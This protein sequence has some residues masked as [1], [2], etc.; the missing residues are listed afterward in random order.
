MKTKAKKFSH[1]LLALF[2]AVIMA[3]TCF[4]G[5]LS[6]FAASKDIKYVDDAVVYNELA[7]PVLSDE[8]VATAILDFADEMIAEYLAPI[9]PQLG[10]LL[11]GVSIPVVTLNH[12]TSKRQIEVKALGTTWVSVTVKLDS[13]DGLLETLESAHEALHG[14]L[15]NLIQRFGL[16]LG[17]IPELDLNAA[18]GLRRTKSSSCDILRGVLGL[19]YENNDVIFGNLLRG[20][21]TLGVIPLDVYDTLGGLFGAPDGYESNFVYNIVQNLLFNNTQWFT[22]EEKTAYLDGSKD[23][24]FDT[25]LLEKMTAEL[26]NKINVLVTYPDGTNSG[27]RKAAIEAKM[28]AEGKTYEQ[29]AAAL[30]YDPNLKYSTE[31]G[32]ENNILLF[33]YGNEKIELKPEDSLFSFGYQALAMAWKTVLKDTVKLLHVNYDVDR[34]H[35]SNFDNQYMYWYT[36]TV[37]A[38][39]SSNPEAMYAAANVERWAAD[40][41]EA[42]DATSADEFL[43]WVKHNFEYDRGIVDD[44][45]GTWRDINPNTLI[46]KIRYSPLADYYFD[47]QTGPIN[48]YFMQLGTANL[49]NFFDNE[50]KEYSSL[51]AGLNDALVAAVK[52]IFVQSDNVYVNE[53]GD[54]TVPTM[55][56]T[57]KTFSTIGDTEIRAI[58]NALTENALDVI[59]YVADT[60]DQNILAAFYEENG[61]GAELTEQNLEEAMIPLLIAALGKINLGSGALK[62]IIHP[63]DWDAAKDAEA[64]VFIALREYLSYVLPQNDYNVYISRD[65]DNNIEATL[66]GTI[67]P[68]A[69]DAIIYIIESAVQVTDDSGKVWKAEDPNHNNKADIFALL[70]NVIC[71][72]ANYYSVPTGKAY[73][74]APLIGLCDKNGNSE[75]KNGDNTT[76]WDNINTLF[77]KFFPVLGEI[78]GKGRGQ[79]DSEEL[80]WE[81]IVMGMLEI[82]AKHDSGFGGVSNFIYRFLSIVSSAP[83][84]SQRIT[85]VVYDVLKDFFNGLFG[86][87]YDGQKWTPIPDRSSTTPFD[88][89]LQK[90]ALAGT[91]SDNVGAVQK[92]INNFVEFSGFGWDGVNTYPDTILPGLLFALNTA[93]NYLKILPGIADHKLELATAEFADPVVEGA[94]ANSSANSTLSF[95]NNCAGVNVAY[96]DGMKDSVTQLSRYYMQIT[97]VKVTG[98]ASVSLG[99]YS[100]DII[101]PGGTVN[102]TTSA[103]YSPDAGTDKCIYTAEIT[104]NILDANKTVLHENLVARAYQYISG[105]ATWASEVYPATVDGKTRVDDSGLYQL[106][107]ELETND[108]N[109]TKT[110]SKGGFKSFTTAQFG[111]SSGGIGGSSQWA[112]VALYPE[113]VVVDNDTLDLVGNYGIR[114]RNVRTKGTLS[115]TKRIDGI[116]YYDDNVSVYDDASGSYKTMTNANAIPVFDKTTGDLLK[117]ERYD[118]STDGGQTWQRNYGSMDN[119]GDTING[120]LGY[121]Y[122]E[123]YGDG[124]DNNKGIVGTIADDKQ[125]DFRVRTHVAYTLQEARD[126]GIIAAFHKNDKTGLYD[127]I[128]LA[129][130]NGTNYDTTLALISMRGPVDGFYLNTGKISVGT[131]NSQYLSFIKY[132]GTTE[133]QPTTEAIDVNVRFYTSQDSAGAGKATYK[134]LY[135]DKSSSAASVTERYDE[136]SSILSNYKD[137]DFSSPE[138][139]ATAQ[140]A[141]TKALAAI[142]TAI[143]PASAVKLN[144]KTSRQ[145]V[146]ASSTSTTGDAAL[147]PARSADTVKI[148]TSILNI[149]DYDSANDLYFYDKEHVAGIYL[150]DEPLTSADV[151]TVNGVLQD[152]CGAPVTLVDG[153]YYYTNSIAYTTEWDTKTFQDAPYLKETGVQATDGSGNKLYNQIQFTHYNM[154]GQNVRYVDQWAV[155]VPQT[156]YQLVPIADGVDTRG[157]YTQTNDYIQWAIEY[158][159]KNIRSDFADQLLEQVSDIRYGLNA[160]NFEVVT[161]NKMVDMGQTIESQYS[162]DI[163]YT[164]DEVVIGA[165]GKATTEAVTYTD[166]ISYKDLNGYLNDPNNREISYVAKSSLSSVQVDEYLRLFNIFMDKVVERGYNGKQLEAEI[167]CAS[168]NPYTA[169][170]VT[171]ATEDSAAVVKKVGDVEPRFGAWSEDG[172]LVNE[173]DP[174]YTEETW[175]AYVNALADAIALAQHGNTDYA[176]ADKAYYD[177]EDKD[178]YDAQVTDVYRVDTALQRA[179]IALEEAPSDDTITI[180][181]TI[182]IAT[183]TT[184]TASTVGIVGIGVYVDGELVATSEKDGTFT[185]VVPKGTT[186]LTIKGDTT[187]DRIVTLTG[188]ADVTGAIIPIVICDYNRDKLINTIDYSV[189]GTALSGAYNVYCDFN[190]DSNV[191]TLDYGVFGA[192]YGKTVVYDALAL[193]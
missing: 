152:V 107:E 27:T 23:F 47:M 76:I 190:G 95:T 113:Y 40:V 96:V 172:T 144:D 134:Y 42:Y 177:T 117:H 135:V 119:G 142:A 15:L 45:T 36:D 74:V 75:I 12:N 185:A 109:Q 159:S 93:N 104:Y 167:E 85:D 6:A 143:T 61:A 184:G 22:D 66:E 191:N 5:A 161:Y 19:I 120:Y 84:Q 2:M 179:E 126:A 71:Q 128:Y 94:T 39:D 90:T 55:R 98:N 103:P 171:T 49:D 69:R 30:G 186:E 133:I 50:Y 58:T 67:L 56:T 164:K 127:H 52:D 170:T 116:Y 8:Q 137:G 140:Q 189:F 145:F 24:K 150:A 178:N 21:F 53:P 34:G 92:V 17:I 125:K 192:F 188:E 99:S 32:Q 81:D 154:N 108:A 165:D 33:A 115:Q 68:M 4:S 77:D 151:R 141:L 156:S 106:N 100:K 31:R 180:S 175:T 65:E 70:N 89:L 51:I 54:I 20:T 26:L 129:T 149:A 132:D 130:G 44:A 173:G 105:A 157:I 7:W 35:G 9:E 57:G 131:N 59:Q 111:S 18:E 176:H 80:I 158:V 182:K 46:N 174:V 163:T 91:G 29:A 48:L 73:G 148:P 72:F 155:M 160:N 60:M 123:I 183:N 181:G 37:G 28:E 122:T 101:A 136:L 25:V 78:Q 38:W 82:S 13:V 83:I 62:D 110:T 168:G 88:D 118:Y 79:L 3:L 139:L 87:R 86:P 1:K 193:D 187:I 147:R 14:N 114:L 162:I 64:I 102:I 97:D 43:G 112:W 153:V 41:Y 166:T 16:D 138:V 121:T 10:D 63:E 169:Y 124:T 146:T 11:S